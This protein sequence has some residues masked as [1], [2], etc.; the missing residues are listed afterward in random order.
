M[1]LEDILSSLEKHYQ[2][3]TYGAVAG[4]VG[5]PARSVMK[6]RPRNPHNSWVVALADGNPTAYQPHEK[7]PRLYANPHVIT[8]PEELAAWLSGRH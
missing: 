7:H 8:S 3:A 6:G 2:R 4:Q 1:N 5:C